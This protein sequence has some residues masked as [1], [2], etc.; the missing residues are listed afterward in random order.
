MTRPPPRLRRSASAA[1][2]AAPEPRPR[3]RVVVVAALSGRALGATSR[4]LPH[5]LQ[6][7]KLAEDIGHPLQQHQILIG[8]S[9]VEIE[10]LTLTTSMVERNAIVL[11]VVVAPCPLI[12]TCLEKP[13]RRVDKNRG[14]RWY[15]EFRVFAKNALFEEVNMFG[16]RR[17]GAQTL[18][19]L[20][21]VRKLAPLILQYTAHGFR[22]VYARKWPERHRTRLSCV[23]G[24]MLRAGV[25]WAAAG[26]F[27]NLWCHY[28]ITVLR[29]IGAAIAAEPRE[30]YFP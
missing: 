2:G 10:G 25:P 21:D 23:H 27:V 17:E 19:G 15:K 28:N 22:V 29:L 20:E 7:D 3:V 1:A 11:P 4:R 8:D 26:E 12:N 13:G 5:R 30:N 14:Q 9:A 24:V 6:R 18:F 16:I